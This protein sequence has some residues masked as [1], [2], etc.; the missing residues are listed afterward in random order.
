[1]IWD[2]PPEVQNSLESAARN[3][4]LLSQEGHG[5]LPKTPEDAA[6]F[7]PHEW[8]LEAMRRAYVM[9]KTSCAELASDLEAEAEHCLSVLAGVDTHDVNLRDHQE[10]WAAIE[11]FAA[12]VRA[13]ERNGPG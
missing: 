13:A 9:G 6:R 8:V 12:K 4:A 1:M 11:S 7:N 3:E 5:Y 2:L 10:A